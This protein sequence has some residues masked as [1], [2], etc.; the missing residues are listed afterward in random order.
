MAVSDSSS[1]SGYW[2]FHRAVADAQLAAWL[3]AEGSAQGEAQ[4]GEAQ[5]AAQRQ[6]LIDISGPHARC[7]ELAT[8]AGHT[9]LRIPDADLSS[10]AD[11]CAD[12]V[13][14]EDR[15]LSMHLAAETVAAEIARVLKPEGRVLAAVDSLVLGMAVLAEQHH[16]AELSDLPQAEVVL[17][18]WPDGMVTRSFGAEQLRELCTD[19]G[20]NVSWIRPRTALAPS[21]VTHLLR[22][23]PATLPRLVAAEL[24]ARTDESVGFQLVVSAYRAKR[25]H[26]QT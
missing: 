26:K 9:V 5:Q 11:G 14:A 13:M 1:L 2:R 15:T 16:W 23:G 19:A 22:R 25:K 10:L 20:L 17:V 12:G 24:A 6:L 8:A 3:P 18:P 4:Q 7:A 21:T